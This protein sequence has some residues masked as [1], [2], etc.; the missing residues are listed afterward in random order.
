M[1]EHRVG[2]D[3]PSFRY[4]GINVFQWISSAPYISVFPVY[5]AVCRHDVVEHLHSI[6]C[7]SIYNV[8][9]LTD[10]GL[11]EGSKIIQELVV[12]LVDHYT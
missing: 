11:G 10:T 7:R 4:N 2:V 1:V 9:K 5:L 6:P 12:D 3:I 8:V